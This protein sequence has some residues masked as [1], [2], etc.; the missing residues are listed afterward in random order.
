VGQWSVM[1]TRRRYP[2]AAGKVVKQVGSLETEG[3]VLIDIRFTDG[4]ELTF[5]ILPQSPKIAS[6]ELLRWRFGDSS[7][8]AEDKSI[9]QDKPTSP[10]HQRHVASH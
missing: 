5:V 9:A 7:V 6:A 8:V 2:G 10:L 1:K 3:E 4:T